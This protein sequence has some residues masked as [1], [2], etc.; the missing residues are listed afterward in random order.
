L[1]ALVLFT[2]V[3]GCGGGD[4]RDGDGVSDK[5]D[6]APANPKIS[7]DGVEVCDGL[8]NDCDGSVDEDWDADSDGF[9]LDDSCDEEVVAVDCNDADAGVFP[10]AQ[11]LCDG[12]D[13]D[14]SGAPDDDDRDGD[15]VGACD[16]CDDGDPFVFPGAAE[17]CDG[18]DN[19]CS[20]GV[21]EPWDIDGDGRSS[22]DGDCNDDDPDIAEGLPELCDG[23]DNDCDDFVDEDP[24]CWSCTAVGDY[25][26]CA[27]RVGWV[28][29]MNTCDGMGGALVSIED[30][31]END[32]VKGEASVLLESYWIGLHDSVT[33]GTFEWLSGA[34]VDFQDFEAG[35][36]DDP[37][38]SSDCVAVFDLGWQ[39]QDLPCTVAAMFVCEY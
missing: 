33:E 17:A 15:G 24:S 38:G 31:T 25:D 36:P 35:Q 4:D 18:V 7:P 10:G 16:D 26:Y 8:D 22:C 30:A 23:L 29:A 5:L 34:P 2:L 3:I 37:N 1:R 9:P 28:T 32:L 13:N 21:D 20:G 12:V 11:E 14:C 27:A 6:C 19:D 39:W